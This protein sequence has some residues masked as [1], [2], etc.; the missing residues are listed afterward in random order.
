M[1]RVASLILNRFAGQAAFS[2]RMLSILIVIAILHAAALAIMVDT[3]PD[4]VSIATFL[5]T[6]FLLNCYWLA[7]LR[8]P[9]AAALVSLAM[10]FTLSS[11]VAVQVR[12]A[13]D[14]G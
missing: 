6:W 8:R 2:R 14:D 13:D 10:I 3:E 7:V 5:F 9:A 4:L 12:Q 1:P 11:A